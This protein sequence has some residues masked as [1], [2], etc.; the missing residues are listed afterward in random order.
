MVDIELMGTAVVAEPPD[1]Q[2]TDESP[3]AAF[4]LD[5]GMGV[6]SVLY[7]VTKVPSDP[8]QHAIPVPVPPLYFEL[9]Y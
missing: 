7:Q 4:V 1:G 3:K 2:L 6:L 9:R 8:P 5:Q